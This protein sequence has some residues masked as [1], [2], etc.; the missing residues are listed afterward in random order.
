[1]KIRTDY[2]TNSSS[3]SFIIARK[4]EMSEKLKRAI[5]DFVED[6]LFGSKMLTPDSTDEQVQKMFDDWHIYED[7][8]E[9]IRK[10]LKDG[11]AVYTGRVDFE[12]FENDYADLLV[13]FWKK[14]EAVSGDEF[15]IID[16]DLS[17]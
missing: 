6:E 7:E 16:G 8:Q 17:Y 11:K 4:E 2:V 12:C 10:V 13:N 5:V 1:M 15:V 3:S 14:L 9:L